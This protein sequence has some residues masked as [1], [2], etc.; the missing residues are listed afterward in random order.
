MKANNQNDH[1]IHFIVEKANYTTLTFISTAFMQVKI[2]ECRHAGC[3]IAFVVKIELV[4][5]SRDQ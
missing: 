3:E 1:H 5:R 4:Q 2:C